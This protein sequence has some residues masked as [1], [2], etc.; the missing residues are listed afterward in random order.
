MQALRVILSVPICVH[1]LHELSSSAHIGLQLGPRNRAWRMDRLKHT[2]LHV[3][4]L[5]NNPARLPKEYSLQGC[6]TKSRLLGINLDAGM[7]T[8]DPSTSIPPP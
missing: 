6:W 7:G 8:G 5:A 1:M 2:V 4:T 3:Q